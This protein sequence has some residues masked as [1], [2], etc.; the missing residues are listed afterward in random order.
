[1]ALFVVFRCTGELK[2]AAVYVPYY[3][4]GVWTASY[5]QVETWLSRRWVGTASVV[6]V[7]LLTG[8]FVAGSHSML[9]SLIKLVVTMGMTVLLYQLC[10]DWKW[11]T[12]VDRFVQACGMHSIGI[13]A[14]HWSFLNISCL[15]NCVR[16]ENEWICL[17]LCVAIACPIAWV[18]LFLKGFL[19]RF[20][21]V[22]GILFGGKWK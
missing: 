12:G 10:T 14:L 16:T 17:A 20:P 22:D 7:L 13:Y 6:S 1:M 3:A 5:E 8:F 15:A 4:M 9:N 19:G 11:Q 18:C 21:V 2:F